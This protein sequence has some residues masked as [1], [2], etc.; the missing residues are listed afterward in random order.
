MRISSK[1]EGKGSVVVARIQLPWRWVFFLSA[2]IA[3]AIGA[4]GWFWS[5]R[6]Y[7]GIEIA[8]AHGDRG[9]FYFDEGIGN[10]E[11]LS[12][13]YST[14]N[15]LSPEFHYAPIPKGVYSGVRFDPITRP[16]EVA[17]SRAF[18]F[19]GIGVNLYEFDLG[20]LRPLKDLVAGASGP[21]WKS[22]KSPSM[23]DL[24]RRQSPLFIQRK[25]E[26]AIVR[27]TGDIKE[28]TEAGF[29]GDGMTLALDGV[30]SSKRPG[31][32]AMDVVG[33]SRAEIELL[34]SDLL[35]QGIERTDEIQ[36][37]QDLLIEDKTW[38]E[39]RPQQLADQFRSFA[40]ANFDPIL[41]LYQGRLVVDEPLRARA[42]A[43]GIAFVWLFVFLSG[44]RGFLSFS[45]TRSLKLVRDYRW[46]I[47]SLLA[48]WAVL[49]F[50][51]GHFTFDL[52]S[53]EAFNEPFG[54]IALNLLDGR[55]DALA[56]SFGGEAIR[57]GGLEYSYMGLWPSVVRLFASPFVPL[58]GNIGRLVFSFVCFAYL[59]AVVLIVRLMARR[60]EDVLDVA[61]R[62]LVTAVAVVALGLGTFLP[63]YVG[64]SYIYHEAGLWAS[65]GVVYSAY[66]L[67]RLTERPSLFLV[68]AFVLAAIV[69]TF[70]RFTS[71]LGIGAAATL[72]GLYAL[73]PRY[74]GKVLA[75]G[76]P[77]VR[78]LLVAG[79][80]LGVIVSALLLVNFYRFGDPV[81]FSPLEDHYGHP[82]ERLVHFGG[83][84]I[85]SE[86]IID[87][88]GRYLSPASFTLERTF[89]YF[90]FITGALSHSRDDIIE[91][92][93]SLWVTIIGALGIVLTGFG[94][95]ASKRLGV[96]GWFVFISVLAP[97][98]FVMA[99][100]GV[101][102]R[103]LMEFLPALTLVTCASACQLVQTRFRLASLAVVSSI[104][105]SWFLSERLQGE[106]VW[107]VPNEFVQKYAAR[108]RLSYADIYGD[109]LGDGERIKEAG[110]VVKVGLNDF[111]P[112]WRHS[113]RA[114]PLKLSDETVGVRHAKTGVI[115]P[116]PADMCPMS[117]RAQMMFKSVSASD[118]PWLAGPMAAAS[119][120]TAA[121]DL[122]IHRMIGEPALWMAQP[123]TLP[124]DPAIYFKNFRAT[125]A[126]FCAGGR[127][128]APERPALLDFTNGWGNLLHAE[129]GEEVCTFVRTTR[130]GYLRGLVA[131]AV[132]VVRG[133]VL[134]LYLYDPVPLTSM[135][136]N[137]WQVRDIARRL[138][139]EISEFRK[140]NDGGS[141]TV[142]ISR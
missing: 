18:V 28:K 30:R 107:G 7:I 122:D 35:R 124:E 44:V 131:G 29:W 136:V 139:D 69:A 111:L 88:L 114:E 121:Q 9:Q 123:V 141:S 27:A 89:P 72:V 3:V 92:H 1:V 129:C 93:I 20:A 74:D 87:R 80:G 63:I 140:V 55:L 85:Q 73:M 11:S 33:K 90:G 118:V 34:I 126:D 57:H 25:T 19:D 45:I 134:Y 106:I 24:Y 38:P 98:F 2:L 61:R 41:S 112:M 5:G 97:A 133:Q 84:P 6:F 99:F 62:D 58:T 31:L 110:Y 12:S 76:S 22:F 104:F 40:L 100:V 51:I 138:G 130:Q 109:M 66:F 37:P 128:E 137:A 77:L 117:F 103:Y 101:T 49:C 79:V 82:I 46:T 132:T 94:M 78:C 42:V 120:C 127:C 26:E 135:S 65:A 15:R 125:F 43:A 75:F 83:T 39:F 102:F 64:R 116:I 60:G 56:G 71:L 68:G 142:T 86:N 105:V 52:G 91:P 21:S 48:C 36:E 108:A 54:S 59:L 67:M 17:I 47:T 113:M 8:S 70:S 32:T 16:G 115:L 81:S 53:P 23:R 119:T 14:S 95:R 50:V 4:F 13:T 10:S 96:V